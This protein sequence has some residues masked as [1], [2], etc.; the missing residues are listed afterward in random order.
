MRIT[1]ELDVDNASF[2]DN[3]DEPW[4]L[5]RKVAERIFL[6]GEKDGN[7]RDTNGNLV[8]AFVVDY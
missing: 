6:E 2:Q 1:I 8:G 3:R 4:V 7:I 5:M